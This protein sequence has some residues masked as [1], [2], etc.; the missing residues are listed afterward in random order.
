MKY[1]NPAGSVKDRVAKA[2]I[3][4]AEEKGLLM[5]RR[6]S[7]SGTRASLNLFYFIA[8]YKYTKDCGA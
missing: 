2:M 8:V 5:E 1:F 7:G 4:D 6:A 3:E